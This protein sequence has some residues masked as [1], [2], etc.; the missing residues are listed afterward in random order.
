MGF[1]SLATFHFSPKPY[2]EETIMT[3]G[4]ILL[5]IA[6]FILVGLFVA[7]PFLRPQDTEGVK[8]EF[9]RLLQEKEHLLDQIQ[10]LDFDH[11]TGK[12]PTE[13]HEI[14]R[15]RLVDQATAVL[16]AIDAG[17]QRTFLA[18]AL[19]ADVDV[20][21]EI[22]AAV[23]RLRQ[24]R[25]Q[26]ETTALPTPAAANGQARFCPQC[27]ALTDP[28]DRFCANCGHNLTLKSSTKTA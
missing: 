25:Q 8:S 1:L 7:R 22:E 4:S 9:E 28:G 13:V 18:P 17:E 12:L 5:G 21:I 6:L 2:I 19:H 26:K 14:Q 20:D 16:Q 24:Q 10:A 23:A 15:V 27:G 3:V 11:E